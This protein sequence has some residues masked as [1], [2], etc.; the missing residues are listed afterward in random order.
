VLASIYSQSGRVKDTVSVLQ[1]SIENGSADARTFVAYAAL[2]NAIDGQGLKVDDVVL[3]DPAD[4]P[5]HVTA[6][7]AAAAYAEA[8]ELEPEDPALQLTSWAQTLITLEDVTA[9]WPVFNQ[10]VDEDTDGGYVRALIEDMHALDDVRPG[11]HHLRERI[12][13]AETPE[14]RVSLALLYLISGKDDDALAALES[15]REL[16]DSAT[17]ISEIDRLWL[18]AQDPELEGFIGEC[19]DRLSSGAPLDEET[20]EEL[21]EIIASAPHYGEAYVLLA[22]A[23]L[24][25]KD[26][27]AALEVLLDAQKQLPHDADV[28]ELL[29]RTLWNTGQRDLALQYLQRGL[30]HHPDN[31]GLLV[32]VGQSLLEMEDVE[33]ARDYIS[34]AELIEPQHPALRAARRRISELLSR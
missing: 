16:T 18:I 26:S 32:R 33:G 28:L 1:T 31:V 13:Q 20:V 21:E 23:Y 27:G 19:I 8:L 29:G 17:L 22:R 30:E 5:R 2:L 10:L 12:R 3:V 4:F 34:R 15:A 6:Y 24:M 11:I 25:W 14:L 7:E 9:F